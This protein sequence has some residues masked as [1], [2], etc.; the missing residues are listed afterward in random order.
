MLGEGS[1]QFNSLR[2]S[3]ATHFCVKLGEIE[4]KEVAP[5]RPNK[6][7]FSG[8][9]FHR[10]KGDG[11]FN[12]SE[13]IFDRLSHQMAMLVWPSVVLSTFASIYKLLFESCR[14]APQCLR[15]TESQQSARRLFYIIVLITLVHLQICPL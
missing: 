1:Q 9:Q 2:W 12:I 15:K 7:F 3:S 5:S 8:S 11:A 4:G 6:P 10:A 13:E 14:I